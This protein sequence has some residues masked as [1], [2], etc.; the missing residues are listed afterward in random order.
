MNSENARRMMQAAKA[1]AEEVGKPVSLAIVNAAG[2]LVALDRFKEPPGF[3]LQV[4][5]GKAVASAVMG[6][7]SAVVAGWGRSPPRRLRRHQRGRRDH[8]QGG[9]RR[10]PDV[11]LG[12]TRGAQTRLAHGRSASLALKHDALYSEN[13]GEGPRV[14]GEGAAGPL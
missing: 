13:R 4:A 8:R 3:T 12:A 5:E 6:F 2:A 7:D 1:K 11:A 14:P 9:R 10:L